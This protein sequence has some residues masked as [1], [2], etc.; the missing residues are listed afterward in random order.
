M[1]ERMFLFCEKKPE[2]NSGF[3][4]LLF[5]DLFYQSEQI[6]ER[7]SH[8]DRYNQGR[9]DR[10]YKGDKQNQNIKDGHCSHHSRK[11]LNLAHII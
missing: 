9:E 11:L 10:Q 5:P 4:F 1:N 6:M 8:S 2:I 3:F 7:K